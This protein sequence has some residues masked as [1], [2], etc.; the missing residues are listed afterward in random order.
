MRIVC[1]TNILISALRFGGSPN[2]IIELAREGDIKLITSPFILHEFERVLREKFHYK[3]EEAKIFRESIEKICLLVNPAS[4]ISIIKKKNDD[5]RILECALKGKV[6]YIVTGDKKHI[7]PLK[8]FQGIKIVT[9]AQFLRGFEKK[10]I[11]FP[12]D[13]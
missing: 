6:D 9:A 4:Q 7:L 1:D 11:I 10:K 5:N 12:G 3:K 13:Y 8:N 2:K